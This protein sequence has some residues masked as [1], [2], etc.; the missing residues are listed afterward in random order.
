[1]VQPAKPEITP[2]SPESNNKPVQFVQVKKEKRLFEASKYKPYKI[3][4]E[5]AEKFKKIY[6][7]L[8]DAK[9]HA[10]S[11]GK[12]MPHL[13][14][15]HWHLY[16]YGPKGKMNVMILSYFQSQWLAVFLKL[17]IDKFDMIN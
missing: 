12:R 17:K 2:L 9:K 14:K 10:K 15:S 13:R 8:E 16:W 7:E 1:M 5:T 4:T 6:E 11:G 3:G